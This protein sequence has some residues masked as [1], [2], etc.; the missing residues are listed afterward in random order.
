M[1]ITIHIPENCELYAA[2]IKRFVDAMVYKLRKNANKGRWEDLGV[3][4][5]FKYLCVEVD[6]LYAE[7]KR[8]S[9]NA[10]DTIF[11]AADVANFAMILSSIV[12]EK[13]R[14]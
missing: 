5:A 13:P 2:D 8:S 14:G 1:D 12:L 9:P 6:E 4:D 10:I 3:S 11:E 7:L